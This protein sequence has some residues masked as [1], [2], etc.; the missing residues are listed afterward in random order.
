MKGISNFMFSTAHVSN[1]KGFAARAFV[2]G[3]A[4]NQP[5]KREQPN[6]KRKRRQIDCRRSHSLT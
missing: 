2:L 3:A 1:I 5:L 4:L 6:I